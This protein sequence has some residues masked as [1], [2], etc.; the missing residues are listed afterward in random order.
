MYILVATTYFNFNYFFKI[1][2]IFFIKHLLITCITGLNFKLVNKNKSL[3]FCTYPNT[4][5]NVAELRSL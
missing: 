5:A 2:N 1:S 3:Q 4:Y